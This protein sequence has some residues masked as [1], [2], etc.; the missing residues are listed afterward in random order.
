MLQTLKA[1]LRDPVLFIRHGSGIR[2]R[3]YQIEP[4][5]AIVNSVMRNLGLTIVIIMARQAGKNELQA[6]IE[7]YL[8]TLLS[9]RN[10]EIVKAS[11]T[12]KPQSLTSIRR[13]R[14]T[15]EQNLFTKALAW[16]PESGYIFRVGSARIYFLSAAE[17]T[18]I[19]GHTASTLLEVDEAQD[20]SPAKFDKDLAPMAASTNATT[21]LWGTVWT[22]NTLLAREQ[23]AA[24][25]AEK[26]DHIRRV[27][28]YDANAVAAEVPAYKKFVEKQIQKLGRQHPLVK[29]QFFLETIDEQGGMFPEW[30]R[31]LMQGDHAPRKDPLQGKIYCA[32]L[33]VAG[34]DEAEYSLGDNTTN[35][36]RDSTIL[37]IVEVDTSTIAD[38]EAPTYRV[39]QRFTWIGT[40]HTLIYAQLRA[41]LEHWHITYLVADAT[42]VGAG[43][44]SFLDKIFPGRVIPFT[45]NSATKSALGYGFLAVTDT[46]RFRD[47]VADHIA[48]P[49]H[50]FQKQLSFVQYKILGGPAKQ[51]QWGVP[52]GTRDP[53]TG[54]LMHDDLVLSAALCSVLDKQIFP[55]GE[56][57]LIIQA[58]DPLADMD[59]ERH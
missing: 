53:S 29:T 47:Y 28:L 59:K 23:Q 57:A 22:S 42:G 9:Q 32:L 17:N 34:Q 4:A 41:I 11:P 26:K 13:L 56:G 58:R 15:L 19:V 25:D 6:Q 46:G 2:L 54:E 39:Q 14:R 24:L 20:V 45:F 16:R 31:L 21:V 3:S 48:D 51:M 35:E 43:L 38:L 52:D 1:I 8:L 7:T 30:R 36:K 5:R 37:T 33:D 10:A 40:R 12:W 55:T 49:A 50:Q 44:V 27:F 18:N